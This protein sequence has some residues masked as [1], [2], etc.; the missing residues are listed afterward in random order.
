MDNCNLISFCSHGKRFCT[1]VVLLFLLCLVKLLLCV[2]NAIDGFMIRPMHLSGTT[3]GLPALKNDAK[4]P[5]Q[6]AVSG[7]LKVRMCVFCLQKQFMFSTETVDSVSNNVIYCLLMATAAIMLT[8]NNPQN[9]VGCQGNLYNCKK[10][11][12]LWLS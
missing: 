9:G 5:N 8:M 11:V 6:A 10:Y 1:I 3:E 4:G 12:I 2:S 7:D